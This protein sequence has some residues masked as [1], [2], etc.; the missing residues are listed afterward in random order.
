MAN[1]TQ[2]INSYVH[3]MSM[4]PDHL[5]S[6]GQVRNLVNGLPDVMAGLVKRPG[7]EIIA[8]LDTNSSG[9]W[10]NIIRD[11]QEKYVGKVTADG[12]KIWTLITGDT[13]D[14]K[15]SRTP[16]IDSPTYVQFSDLPYFKGMQ[17]DD[18]DLLTINDYTIVLNKKA[19][20]GIGGATSDAQ[21]YEGFLTINSL[22][23]NADYNVELTELDATQVN[24]YKA[25][26]ISVSPSPRWSIR[27]DNAYNY[28]G[29]Q[30]FTVNSGT[31]T[32]LRFTIT[33]NPRWTGV[34]GYY[35]ETTYDVSFSLHNGG[36]GWRVG[37]QVSVNLNGKGYT[38][39]VT[40]ES[41]VTA[42]TSFANAIHFTPKDSSAGN[43]SI[44]DV[45]TDLKTQ[46]ETT[47]DV[48]CTVIGPGLYIKYNKPFSIYASGGQTS[49][50]MKAFTDSIND[51]G[52]LPSQCKDGYVVKVANSAA[53]EDDY[54]MQFHGKADGVDGTGAWEEC[55]K[56]GIPLGFDY[57]TMPHQLVRMSDGS[58]LLSPIEWENRLVGDEK[59]NPDPSFVGKT[60]N[61]TLFY[62]NRLT[63]LSDENIIQ[64]QS[65]D[66]FN[67]F[68]NTAMTVTDND[69]IDLAATST[70]PCELHDA[71]PMK[72]GLLLF[73]RDRQFLYGTTL[74]ILSPTTAKIETLSTYDWNEHIK[75]ADMGT[76]VGFVSSAGKYSRFFELTNLESNNAPEALEQSKI[77][78]ELLPHDLDLPELAQSKENTLLGFAKRNTNLVYMYRYFNDG[79]KRLMSSWFKWEL[80]GNLHHH[81]IDKDIYYTVVEYL[82]SV[83]VTKH[84][85]TIFAEDYLFEP[86]GFN[87]VPRLDL[88]TTV[89]K[90]AMTYDKARKR[91]SFTL[92]WRAGS[93][94]H[95]FVSEE[96]KHMGRSA[97]VAAVT[98]DYT[99][100]TSAVE[101]DGDWTQTDVVVGYPYEFRV[102]IPTI[103]MSQ[104]RGDNKIKSDTRSYLTVHRAKFQ[105][106]D[107]GVFTT[108]VE[109]RSKA[110]RVLLWEQTP[111][112]H[113]KA[114]RHA[115][116]PTA[117][118]TIPCYEKNEFLEFTLT[119]NHPTPAA[120]LSMEWEG[121][122]S[123]KSYRSV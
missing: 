108:T 66:Y 7:S 87:Y 1:I 84:V 59:T 39:T 81:F 14:V 85:L 48:T 45:L 11:N 68:V 6:P 88:R 16:G 101:L 57:D 113:Y 21:N 122:I 99:A 70:S 90:S 35:D 34:P 41:L 10:F 82:G 51:V 30:T 105:F 20:V 111:G 19:V 26:A 89:K 31:K 102:E 94:L 37:D 32:G 104:D 12:F 24:D 13:R 71:I 27:D 63:F 100:S 36:R 114:N 69:P 96:G 17:P 9:R 118:Q 76:T 54:Y 106:A 110:D 49:Y 40:K 97:P 44:N 115:V 64:S 73:S 4:Q 28:A 8:E 62:R 79:S 67:F 103:Y 58:F 60:I 116:M 15:Y 55:V 112:D 56:P 43:V 46:L 50:S 93:E 38:I 91:T 95:A 78:S 119:S 23:Y 123:P 61:R 5:K 53:D 52:D 3:G 72:I 77:V 18:I 25:A 65:G 47:P 33:A 29:T 117:F 92:N 2:K 83:F 107:V 74:D 42:Y 121:K 80:K 98:I 109:A 75:V 120:L 86:K 22:E